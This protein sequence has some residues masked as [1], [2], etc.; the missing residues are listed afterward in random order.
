MEF[1]SGNHVHL[2]QLFEYELLFQKYIPNI[3]ILY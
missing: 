3:N 2:V 1:I